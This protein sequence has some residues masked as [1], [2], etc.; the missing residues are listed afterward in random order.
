MMT[1]VINQDCSASSEDPKE[2][3]V[4]QP[5]WQQPPQQMEQRRRPADDVPGAGGLGS[6][7]VKHQGSHTFC[8]DAIPVFGRQ[9]VMLCRQQCMVRG[10]CEGFWLELWLHYMMYH[11]E[12]FPT[13]NH[14][15]LFWHPFRTLCFV[16]VEVQQSQTDSS[17]PAHSRGYNVYVRLLCPMP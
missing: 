16:Q 12:C 4:E 10:V 17:G 5:V 2:N 6:Q 11:A 13:L 9:L 1:T 7:R 8:W 14:L 15:A 3:L